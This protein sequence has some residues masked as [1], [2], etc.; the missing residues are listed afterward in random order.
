MKKE[1]LQWVNKTYIIIIL[2]Y[3]YL[4]RK[5]LSR[6]FSVSSFQCYDPLILFICMLI[7][8]NLHSCT[9]H[10]SHTVHDIF[11]QFKRNVLGKDN[12]SRAKN[13]CSPI[14]S[15]QVMRLWV[16]FP[17]KSCTSHTSVTVWVIFMKLYRNV[18][19]VK[20]MCRVE[21]WMFSVSSFQC[22]APWIIFPQNSCTPHSSVT[23]RD[24]FLHLNTCSNV[25]WVTKT[26]PEYNDCWIRL[27]CFIFRHLL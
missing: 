25:C 11:M 18:Y 1:L 12:V 22:Y 24:I 14:L 19:Q 4:N 27:P 3:Y 17:K 13:G 16:F 20:T 21:L 8:C 9:F 5:K 7:L 26:C 2:A 6:L 10:N 23:V 15:F